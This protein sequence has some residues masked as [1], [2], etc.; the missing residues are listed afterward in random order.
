MQ[1]ERGYSSG[2]LAD[3]QNVKSLSFIQTRKNL[4]DALKSLKNF[5]SLKDNILKI[6]NEID[7]LELTPTQARNK[8]TNEIS[9][10][11]NYINIM[12]TLVDN[13]EDR[14]YLQAY[15]YLVEAKDQLGRIRATLYESFMAKSLSHENFLYTK[16]SLNI[17]NAATKR[18]ENTLNQK[19]KFLSFYH[20][21]LNNKP[22]K[23]MFDIIDVTLETYDI[24]DAQKWFESATQS[25]DLFQTLEIKLFENL[26]NSINIKIKNADQNIIL[27]VVSLVLLL[28]ALIYLMHTIINKILSS[29]HILNEEF[30]TSLKLLEQYRTT[31]DSSFI[32]SKTDKKGVIRY[33]NGAFCDISGYTQEELLGKPHNIIR[34]P[35]TP[36]QTFK[37]MWHTI[38]ELKK[39]WV[40]EIKNLAKDGSSYWMRAF[41]NPI[42]DKNGNIIE[43]IA[44]RT[45]ITELQEDK[46]R[47]RDTLGITTADF[48]E[49]RHRVKEY[50][51]AINET[52]SVIRTD[53]NNI[54]TYMNDTFIKKSG[55]EKEELMGRDCSEFRDKKHII[56]GDCKSVQRKLANKEVVHMQFE[57]L[58]KGRIPCYMDTTIIPIA[59]SDGETIE[60]LH[61]MS[62]V[63]E[64]VLMHQE[65]ENT[66]QEI[67]FRMG[68][69]G[70]SRNRETGNHVRR[71]ASYARI[72]ALKAGLSERESELIAD[73]SPMHDI[74]KVAIADEILLKPGSFEPHEWEIMKTHS[75]IGYKVLSGSKRELLNT[76]AIIAHEHHEKYDGSG[77]P[78]ELAGEDIHIY[79]RIVAIADVFDALGSDRVYKKKWELD[80]IL[81]FFEEQKGKHFDPKLVNIFLENLYEFLEIRE[82][83]KD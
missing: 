42:L 62:D 54:I 80:K 29:T 51:N 60:H 70:E 55:Y 74:G 15:S 46:E 10:L 34:H 81:E 28:I 63:T 13:I 82:K 20:T 27:V 5:S 40:G 36:K 23:E 16:E 22:I 49:A 2:F 47:I 9:Y 18:F 72:L 48:A 17:Y 50:E 61:L 64:L 77:Y 83:Y 3:K 24:S 8:Y 76:S 43:Y 58:T 69:I 25:I 59:N 7:R 41:I 57:N 1:R 65:I 30:E 12:P 75:S 4:D 37:E 33:V 19:P 26:Q 21:T 44:M 53:T 35:D 67:I 14:N 11:L 78:R 56:K 32:V 79:A 45:N 52:W 68:E 71:V 73:A 31:V 6:R 38:K 39:P 66:Q